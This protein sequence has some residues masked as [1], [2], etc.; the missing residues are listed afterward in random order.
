MAITFLYILSS[1]GLSS[2][3]I[4]KKIVPCAETTWGIR[5]GRGGREGKELFEGS[6]VTGR[7]EG[8]GEGPVQQVL[9]T[10]AQLQAIR[11]LKQ[12]LG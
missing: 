6:S 7:G 9:G 10:P 2:F 3:S 8:P 1:T 12:M 5:G 11:C 4:A